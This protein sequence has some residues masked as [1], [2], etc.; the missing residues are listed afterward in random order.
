MSLLRNWKKK[1]VADFMP[2]NAAAQRKTRD[3][4]RFLPETWKAWS[5]A[6]AK[7]GCCP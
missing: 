7:N 4:N 6:Q 3:S 5:I 2:S 1:Q